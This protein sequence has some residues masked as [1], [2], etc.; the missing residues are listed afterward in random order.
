MIQMPRAIGAVVTVMALLTVRAGA[1]T[2]ADTPLDALLNL[3][4]SAAAKYEQRLADVPASVT[5]V[6]REEI[7]RFGYASLAEVLEAMRGLYLSYD[8]N[9]TYVGVRGFSR[10]TD[11]N[12][13][14]LLLIDDHPMTDNVWGGNP[15]GTDLVLDLSAVERIEV[16]RGPSSVF[17]G[18]GAMFAVINVVT[19]TKRDHNRGEAS[20]AAGSQRSQSASIHASSEFATDGTAQA[21]ALWR[22]N[23]GQRHLYFPEFDNAATNNGVAENRDYDNSH[24][25]VGSLNFRELRLTAY[26]GDRRKGIPTGVF[27]STFNERSETSDRRSFME[28]QFDHKIDDRKR[29]TTRASFDQMNSDGVYA[30]QFT[31]TSHGRWATVEGRMLWDPRPDQRWTFGAQYVHNLK[32]DYGYMG[33]TSGGFAHPFDVASIY[34]QNEY[35]PISRLTFIGGVRYDHQSDAGQSIS[36]RLAL[37]IHPRSGRTIKLLAGDAHRVPNLYE[38]YLEDYAGGVKSNLALEPEQVRTLEA[39][40]EERLTPSM[41]ATGSVYQFTASGLIEQELDRNDYLFQYHNVG[42]ASARGV[43]MQLD[44]RA[45]GLWTYTSYAIQKALDDRDQELT[46]SPRH[47][48]KAGAT[49]PLAGRGNASAEILYDSGRR[50]IAG[51]ETNSYLGMNVSMS[52]RL[53]PRLQVRATVRN[54]LNGPYVT[55]ASVEHA[56]DTIRR[57]G[58]TCQLKV[59]YGF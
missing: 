22:Q 9:Y 7:E 38:K 17:Y 56:A 45:A 18:T 46:N 11:Y 13:R 44:Y 57:E 26:T 10:P 59:T 35:Q 19:N 8:R 29:I 47:L 33:V 42:Q 51:N 41:F 20:A 52:W 39:V 3:P 6:S 37:I 34:V 30:G 48:I 14:V 40:W 53:T 2:P 12:N 16:V 23:D 55:P 25:A 32:A 27:G 28:L 5:I 4:I 54:L 50:T 31:E 43:E 15:V 49:V 24:G 58:R 36:P 1:Q 21:T